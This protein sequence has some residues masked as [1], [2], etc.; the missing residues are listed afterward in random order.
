[1]SPIRLNML[2]STISYILASYRL[3]FASSI[4]A[5]RSRAHHKA[6]QEL[7]PLLDR[8]VREG[9]GEA[10]FDLKNRAYSLVFEVAGQ[11][12]KAAW[13]PVDGWLTVFPVS[14]RSLD[15]LE[16]RAIWLSSE[17]FLTV[18]NSDGQVVVP[19]SVKKYL[20]AW[21]ERGWKAA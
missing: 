2:F 14:Q 6:V 18:F 3:E 7:K 12:Y 8:L 1:M 16:T 13:S 11:T 15:K 9:L 10:W 17:E 20:D 21:R 5:V 4:P 19:A